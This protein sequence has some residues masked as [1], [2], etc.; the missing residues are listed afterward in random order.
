MPMLYY[1]GQRS[2]IFNA[3]TFAYWLFLGVGHSIIVFVLPLYIYQE[4]L[5]TRESF[6]ND[7][8]SFSV[9]SFTSVILVRIHIIF[10]IFRLL[11]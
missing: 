11:L 10:I 5:L 1:I 3:K 7:L 6:N 2:L 8:W 9:S 4:C